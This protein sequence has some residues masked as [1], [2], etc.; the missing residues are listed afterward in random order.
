[1]DKFEIKE[2]DIL[3]DEIGCCTCC[4]YYVECTRDEWS[5][6]E[7]KWNECKCEDKVT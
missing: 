3:F 5:L 6:D 4:P 7:C 1:M 2:L